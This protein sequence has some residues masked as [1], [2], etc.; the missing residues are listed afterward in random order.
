[1]SLT[2][3]KVYLYLIISFINQIIKGIIRIMTKMQRLEENSAN[4]I[5]IMNSGTGTV[6]LIVII[7]EY[8]LRKVS[9]KYYKSI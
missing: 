1:L 6:F 8:S 4:I 5:K 3:G 7:L 9:Q 2:F